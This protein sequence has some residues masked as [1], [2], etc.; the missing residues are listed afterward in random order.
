M[1]K[2]YTSP[3]LNVF[4]LHTETAILAYSYSYGDDES[5]VVW[6][7]KKEMN[8]DNKSPIWDTDLENYNPYNN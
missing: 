7:N 5:D 3:A 8:T 2:I 1:K 4:D 6:T